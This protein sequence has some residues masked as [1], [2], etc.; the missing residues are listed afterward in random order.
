MN[1]LIE[2]IPNIFLLYSVLPS[3]LATATT[4]LRPALNLVPVGGAFVRFGNY[5][6]LL[7]HTNFFDIW[8]NRLNS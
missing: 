4:G 1:Q 8:P 6:R 2:C 5:T 3:A 7:K